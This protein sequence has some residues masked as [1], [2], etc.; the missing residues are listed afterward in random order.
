MALAIAV[1]ASCDDVAR[2]VTTACGLWREVL[3][4]TFELHGLAARHPVRGHEWLGLMT[5][6]WKT[7]VVAMLPL[8]GCCLRTDATDGLGHTGLP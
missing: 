5:A 4:R 3:G 1:R 8:T 2:S 6:H 7:A